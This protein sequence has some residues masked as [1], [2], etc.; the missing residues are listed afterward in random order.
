M[1]RLRIPADSIRVRLLALSALLVSAALIAGYLVIAAILES[2]ILDRFDAETSAVA[3]AIIAGA[4]V[5]DDGRLSVGTKPA[6]PRFSIP[7]SGWYWQLDQGDEVVA[8]SASLFDSTL[9][10]QGADRGLAPPDTMTG[11]IIAGAGPQ[12]LRRSFAPFTLP[13]SDDRLLVIVTAPLAE[14]ESSL[15]DVRRPL[16][17]SLV[18]LGIALALAGVVQVTAGLRS[19]DRLGTDL[20][21]V[22]SGDAEHLP[23]PPVAELRPISHEINNLLDHNR[24]VLARAREHVGNLAHSLKT[25]LSALANSLPPDHAGQGLIARMDRQIGWHLRR[26]RSSAAPRLLGQRTPVAPV[27]DDILLVLRR[28]AQDAGLDV[29]VDCPPHLAFAGERQ[30]LEEMIGNLTE[31]AVKWAHSRIRLR[32]SPGPATPASLSASLQIAI[33]DDGPGLSES[34]YSRALA[35]GSRLD[36]SGP[37][38]AGLGLAIV[39]DIA[40]L[41]GGKLALM[42]SD[43]GGLRTELTLPA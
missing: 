41:H 33:E 15:S 38:G 21:R 24:N 23:L 7:L 39:T 37:P 8:K 42:Q 14:I 22:R 6:D 35:R 13:D 16:A 36:E 27:I 19:L 31:N 17:I 43:L 10:A 18:I 26:A 30:D 4:H 29:Q 1:R 2:F 11:P 34:Q 25:P 9:D 32:A 5:L 28:A 40:A 20:R 3:D 12:L